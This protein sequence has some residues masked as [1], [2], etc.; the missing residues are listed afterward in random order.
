MSVLEHFKKKL[1]S[2]AIYR[3]HFLPRSPMQRKGTW[4]FIFTKLRSVQEN[5]KTVYFPSLV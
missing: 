1:G 2:N 3:F 5:K 4:K